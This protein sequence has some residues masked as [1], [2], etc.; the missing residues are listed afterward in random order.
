[1][2]YPS[3]MRKTIKVIKDIKKL[4][5]STGFI[6]VLCM[7]LFEDFHIN[8]EEIHEV[9]FRKRL[10]TKEA[11]LLLGFLIQDNIDF[12]RPKVPEDIIQLK[13]KTYK[14]ME[15]LHQSFLIA[16]FDKLKMCLNLVFKKED[17]RKH[18]KDFFGKGDM[19]VEPIFYS[20]TG[21]YD[22][23]Y[24]EFLDKKYKYDSKWLF[25]NKG[26]DFNKTKNIIYRIKDILKEKSKKVH[27]YS[28]KESLPKII[29]NMK[30]ETPNEDWG[31]IANDILP[32]ME[33]H[34]YVE[35]FLE[36]LKDDSSLSIDEIRENGWE[37][38]F[39]N[40]VELFVIRKSDFDSA[41]DIETF[42][43][44]FSITPQKGLNNQFKTIGNYN[45]INSHPIIKL[46]NEKYF[47][48]SSFLLFEAAYE[49]P[50]YWMLDDKSYN[51]Q[52][53]ENRG[54]VG[55]EIAYEFLS[56]VFKTNNI[57]KSV[58]IT[59][60]KGF[61][62][63]DI[64]VLCVLGSKALCVQVKS[65]KL[66]ELSRKGD[67][68]ALNDDFQKAVQDAYNQGLLSRNK[69]LQKDARFLDMKGNEIK[70]SENINEVYIMGITTENYP[71]LTHQSHVMLDKQNDDPFPIVLTIFDL[72]LLVH[73]L[74]DPFDFLYYIK[75]R[76]SLMD[77]F[78][79]NE[80]IAFLGYHLVQKLWKIPDV[81]RIEI[82][83]DFGQLIDR[84]YYP[85]KAGLKVS[86]E[87][88]AIK[89]RWQNKK[90]DLICNAI[91][92]LNEAKITDI[93]FHLFDWSSEDRTNLVDFI[94]STKIKTLND[95]KSHDFSKLPDEISSPRIGITYFSLNS[96]NH[97][98]LKNRLLSLCYLRK[99]KSKGD[100]W[101]GFGSL[102]HS[103]KM[104]DFVA[105]NDQEWKYDKELEKASEFLR[106][107]KV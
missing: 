53:G 21:I 23:Q 77:Y 79:A 29:G 44:N 16:F 5:T 27:F 58:K 33:M 94:S 12:S 10:S 51:D 83:S 64:D 59:S 99:Y 87:G 13:Q 30:K 3:N 73:Y 72:E 31:K 26:F 100:V 9:N 97:E 102:I 69:I 93:L 92:T 34:Q 55:E 45:I 81:D 86:D 80:E 76:T 25:E 39:I 4:V 46:D 63:T 105:F 48:P 14:L 68:K 107:G 62:D 61:D 96:D 17:L 11:S 2:D 74:N 50:F 75:Q 54:E 47:V 56:K 36:G 106:E 103:P 104:I 32:L 66:T 42:L 95:K 15:K 65:K 84:N 52:A 1:M 6:Y 18:Q 101:I 60:K 89:K 28:L 37:S 35:L 38:F 71:S 91:K 90:F 57:Y 22:F 70:L 67:N 20:G 49:N 85:I 8:L 82:D 78:V 19:I 40:L 7:L 43:N 88:D 98:E 41:D 24:L